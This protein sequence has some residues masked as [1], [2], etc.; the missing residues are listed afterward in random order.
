MRS[1]NLFLTVALV[2]AVF[3]LGLP[4]TTPRV[5][6]AATPCLSAH[7]CGIAILSPGSGAVLK[8]N[9]DVNPSFIVSFL[10]HNITLQQPG[11]TSDVN[12]TIRSGTSDHNE[13]H[14]HV[15]FDYI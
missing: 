4:S 9:T 11:L 8:K 10:V 3:A 2:L 13:G 12:T 15:F 5:Y 6:G 14:I 7:P 1:R